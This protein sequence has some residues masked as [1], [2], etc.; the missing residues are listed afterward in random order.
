MTSIGYRIR[1]LRKMHGYTQNDLAKYLQTSQSYIAKLENDKLQIN[2]EMLKRLSL[3]YNCNSE[4]ISE[5]KEEQIDGMKS[6]V[7]N[8]NLNT[9]VKMNKII[10]NLEYLSEI[11]HDLD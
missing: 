8:L 2:D 4:Y 11:T 5:G 9:I 10:K 7:R 3:L 6:N 1:K